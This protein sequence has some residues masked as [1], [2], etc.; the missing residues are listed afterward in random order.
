MSRRRWPPGTRTGAGLL[1]GLVLVAVLLPPFLPDPLAQPDLLRG[2]SLAPSLAHPF[3]TDPLSRDVL[4]RTISGA[5]WSLLIAVPAVLLAIA[6]G[7]TVGLAAGVSGGALDTVLM[8]GTDGLLAVPRLFILLLLL[9]ATDALPAWAIAVTIGATGWFGLAKLV[10]ADAAR[11][12]GEEF[13]T[14]ARALGASRRRI[15]VRHLLPNVVGPIAVSATVGLGDA[16]LLEAGLSFLGLGLQPPTPSWG[17]MLRD[18]REV[19]A[20]AP[21]VSLFPGLFLILTVLG[22]HLLA[23]AL[24]AALDPRET[25]A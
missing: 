6:L 11:L 12:R 3:G 24:R 19:L 25:A 2:A 15:A 7:T 16:I 9:A 17:G 23:D 13:V 8:R 20:T 4:A 10:R 21:W 22:A 5:R 14:A 1:V 18:G